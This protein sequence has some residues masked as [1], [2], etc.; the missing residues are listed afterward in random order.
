MGHIRIVT[1]ST[2]DLSLAEL[3]QYKISL[4]PVMI[5]F[6]QQT[7]QELIDLS[8]AQFY[9][10]MNA[11]PELPMTSQ[12]SPGKIQEV[13]ASLTEG[14]DEVMAYFISGEL[15][16]SAQ[17]ARMLA[18]AFPEGRITVVD[19]RSVSIGLGFMVKMAAIAAAKGWSGKQILDMTNYISENMKIYFVV[20]HLDNLRKGGRIGRAAAFLGTMLNI[21]PLL[22]IKDGIVCPVERIRGKGKAVEHMV[23]LVKK[24]INQNP[25]TAYKLFLGHGD[26]LE[27]LESY[28]PR[29]LTQL[30]AAGQ[31]V[32]VVEI[33]AAVGTH[34]GSG[35]LALACLPWPESWQELTECK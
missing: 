29:I 6:G 31:D 13:F 28:K 12:P 16:G 25:D 27:E 17:T 20:D 26:A 2:G 8:P 21:R 4:L 35:L 5:S 9:Q 32:P 19:S 23:R 34:T 7:Y 18:G 33:G 3:H 10:A 14:G 11:A 15:S 30:A 24:T 22:E 1:D